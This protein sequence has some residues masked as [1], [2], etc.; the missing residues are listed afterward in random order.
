MIILDKLFFL[1][2]GGIPKHRMIESSR[3]NTTRSEIKSRCKNIQDRQ[4]WSKIEASATT[5]VVFVGKTDIN[6]F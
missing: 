5:T 4:Y 6:I 1:N 2:I 3:V